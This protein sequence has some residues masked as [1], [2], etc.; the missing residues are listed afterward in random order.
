MYYVGLYPDV[1]AVKMTKTTRLNVKAIR[2]H[3][4]L[5]LQTLMVRDRA[6]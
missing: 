2:A 1:M 6:D 3:V 5:F 4:D